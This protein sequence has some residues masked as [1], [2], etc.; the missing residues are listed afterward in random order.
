[1][2]LEL[3][4]RI[5]ELNS[6]FIP[7]T[8]KAHNETL[9]IRQQVSESAG[10]NVLLPYQIR[11]LAYL[12]GFEDIF[13]ALDEGPSGISAATYKIIARR[14]PEEGKIDY[15]HLV[16]NSRKGHIAFTTTAV[17]IGFQLLGEERKIEYSSERFHNA[18]QEVLRKR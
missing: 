9:K 17:E 1:M 10:Y 3:E 11:E 15:A 6:R 2:D 4:E 16:K 7:K 18:L 13:Y 12:L 14:I 8:I 5:M